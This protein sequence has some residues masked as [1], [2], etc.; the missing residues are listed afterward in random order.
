[1]RGPAHNK[2]SRSRGSKKPTRTIAYIRVSTEDQVREGVSLEAQE[3]R[4]CAFCEATGR[5]N[6]EIIRDDGKSAKD[7][8]RPG[9]TALLN[10]VQAG[11]VDAIIVLKLDR[12][13]RSVRDLLD[14]F[15]A[16]DTA[17]VSVTE[18]LD[19]ATA[20]GRLMLHLLASVSQWE[21][22][23]IAERTV[24]ALAHMR[25]ERKVYG[26]TPFGF[27]RVDDS[28][29]QVDAEQQVLLEMKEKYERGLTYREIG[30]WLDSIG[31]RTAR[32]KTRWFANS[33]RQVLNSSIALETFSSSATMPV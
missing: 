22:E 32:G 11:L 5:A 2:S 4:L 26:S 25:A 9:M 24:F 15:T 19:T 12:L 23:T 6:V 17:L 18:S 7:L 16:A 14:T 20:G 1:M 28:L 8:H 31:T 3:A 30:K 10:E 13:T 21:R 33:V 27:Q 29:V